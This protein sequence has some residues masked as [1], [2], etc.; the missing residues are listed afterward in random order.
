MKML[1]DQRMRLVPM[2]SNACENGGAHEGN[3]G[4][5]GNAV[6]AVTSQA[7]A[8]GSDEAATPVHG[9]AGGCGGREPGRAGGSRRGAH[10]L[11]ARPA[12]QNRAT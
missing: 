7:T 5:S 11:A 1:T 6:V 2:R 9:D 12:V 4:A 10:A 8:R 3:G